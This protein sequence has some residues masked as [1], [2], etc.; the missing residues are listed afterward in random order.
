MSL[1]TLQ[2]H[3]SVLHGVLSEPW[4]KISSPP[5]V[6]SWH[7]E[8][9]QASPYCS[10]VPNKLSWGHLCTPLPMWATLFSQNLPEIVSSSPS[11]AFCTTSLCNPSQQGRLCQCRGVGACRED[12]GLQKLE[13]KGTPPTSKSTFMQEE[14]AVLWTGVHWEQGWSVQLLPRLVPSIAL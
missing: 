11:T 13:I 14:D 8:Q 3:W 5:A 1:W 9:L 2:C 10:L 4:D 6:I 12:R 7:K